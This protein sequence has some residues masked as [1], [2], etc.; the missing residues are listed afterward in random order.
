MKSYC[1]ALL[2]LVL[3]LSFRLYAYFSWSME[4]VSD[5]KATCVLKHRRKPT[6]QSQFYESCQRLRHLPIKWNPSVFSAA[7]IY[8]LFHCPSW[9]TERS[10]CQHAYLSEAINDKLAATKQIWSSSVGTVLSASEMCWCYSWIKVM[11]CLTCIKGNIPFKS[12]LG[13][14]FNMCKIK[15]TVSQNHEIKNK[16]KQYLTLLMAS[17]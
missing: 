15:I 9:K 13:M 17:I 6:G 10:V 11:R 12:P 1:A 16:I 5:Y 14:F 2:Q 4:S 8:F 7:G 3:H